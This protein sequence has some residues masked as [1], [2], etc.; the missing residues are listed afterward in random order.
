MRGVTMV[1]CPRCGHPA[2]PVQGEPE[3]TFRPAGPELILARWDC[4]SCGLAQVLA[5]RP[6]GAEPVELTA[7]LLRRATGVDRRLADELAPDRAVAGELRPGWACAAARALSGEPAFRVTAAAS[8]AVEAGVARL[9]G[10]DWTPATGTEQLELVREHFDAVA[11]WARAADRGEL[12]PDLQPPT[13]V[14]DDPGLARAALDRLAVEPWYAA[15]PGSAPA[16]VDLVYWLVW[17]LLDAV[18][19]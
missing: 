10:I 3:P 14:R 13:L 12:W 18:G 9:R 4:P 1:S 11:T 6:D 19:D 7:A 8:A 15:L 16:R 5:V 17:L 2:E